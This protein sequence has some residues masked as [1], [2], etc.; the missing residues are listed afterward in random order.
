MGA[1]LRAAR[2]RAQAMELSEEQYRIVE[3]LK[4]AP[5]DGVS[6]ESMAG[7][8]GLDQSKIWAALSDWEKRGWVV[9]QETSRSEVR[10]VKDAGP[11]P[12]RRLLNAL[13]SRDSASM[14]EVAALASEHAFPMGEALKWGGRKGWFRVEGGRLHVTEGGR[15]F[16]SGQDED[17][18]AAVVL[19]GRGGQA[20]L[21]ELEASGVD[22]SRLL[23]ICAN[24]GEWIKVKA[25]KVKRGRLT[26]EGRALLEGQASIKEEKSTLTSEEIASGAWREIRLK[27]YDVSLPAETVSPAK[28][29]PLQKIL[30]ETRMAFLE[31]GFTEVVSPEVESAFWD[32]D[33]LF[34][35][36]D[37]PA[38]DMQ[39]TFYLARPASMKL[40]PADVVKRVRETHENG[41]T[42]GSR[43][44]GYRWD[45]GRAR[46]A[47]LRT[48]TTAATV[49]ALASDPRPPRKVFC[50]G[51]VFR[52]EAI[53]FKHLPEFHQVDGIIIDEKA[54]FVALLG[55]LKEFYRKMGFEQI[56]F[57]P[58][59]FPYTEPSAEV[60][61]YMLEKKQWIELGGSGVFRPEVTEPFGCT[62]PVL[63]WGL[64]LERLAMLRYEVHDIR[65]L[66]WTD[67][68]W[69]R[70]VPLCR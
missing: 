29:H 69:L 58:A 22:G 46:E 45:E 57:K 52:N 8:T 28:V 55:L 61:G 36:Q 39:D 15:R 47:V 3:A 53:N 27:P 56:R 21:D 9:L 42:T 18:K 44:W 10:L 35:P 17:E 16:G 2:K 23:A 32:F 65:N 24:R 60:Y 67:L 66:Y 64:G 19:G 7:S 43:G 26:D 41:G 25:R 59:F 54:S 4:K 68:D 33:A 13:G 49:R 62:V 5:P 37:H 48:H 30:Q 31:M 50:V 70:G 11:L 14:Q 1:S 51:T 40:P 38:R 6:I 20:F 12:E 63:A 34:Q